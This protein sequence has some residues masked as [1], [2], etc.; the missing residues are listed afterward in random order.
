MGSLI[1]TETIT[2]RQAGGIPPVAMFLINKNKQNSARLNRKHLRDMSQ[3]RPH[4]MRMKNQTNSWPAD[5]VQAVGAGAW[6]FV[7]EIL[8]EGGLS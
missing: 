8:S 6:G 2:G 7:Y 3:I 1:L 4:S 5:F